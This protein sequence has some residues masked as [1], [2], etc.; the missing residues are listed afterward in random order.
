M[1]TTIEQLKAL[2]PCEKFVITGSFAL[3][4]MGLCDPEKVGDIDIIL[5]NPTEESLNI[6]DRLQT[7][8][9]AKTKGYTNLMFIFMHNT[10]V[11]N[12]FI[13]K[14]EDTE[15]E[16]NGTSI[17]KISGIVSAKK[18]YGRMKDWLQ[19]RKLAKFFFTQSEFDK[20]LDSK[21]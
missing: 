20:F 9:P 3:S 10:H 6:C 17:S 21:I 15:L 11:V 16:Y 8:N 13:S 2:L 5:V 18:S 1:K 19:L 12:I 14:K 7:Q 4:L